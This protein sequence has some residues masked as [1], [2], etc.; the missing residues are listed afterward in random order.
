M[1]SPQLAAIF[2]V[3][4]NGEAADSPRNGFGELDAALRDALP[5][6]PIRRL[7]R[8]QPT[9]NIDEIQ[10]INGH[11]MWGGFSFGGAVAT[12]A[13]WGLLS[14][15]NPY[16]LKQ[17]RVS[18]ALWDPVWWQG[19]DEMGMQG[20]AIEIEDSPRLSYVRCYL[21]TQI[22]WFWPLHSR[23]AQPFDQENIL[24]PKTWHTNLLKQPQ[25]RQDFVNRAVEVF[26]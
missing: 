23:L 20:R 14:P 4:G 24:V 17:M 1:T 5:Q 9:I 16:P 21:R 12:R 26:S 13:V 19:N 22:N 18:L 25:V 2:L 10:P 6:V 11:V 15:A 7:A 3:Q 8:T